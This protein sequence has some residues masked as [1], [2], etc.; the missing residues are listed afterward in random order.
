MFW[1]IDQPSWT[2]WLQAVTKS[3]SLDLELNSMSTTVSKKCL[4]QL[5]HEDKKPTL[6]IKIYI[7]QLFTNYF[8]LL[9][10]IRSFIVGGKHT[11]QILWLETPTC[12]SALLW[13]LTDIQR[14]PGWIS[15]NF[16]FWNLNG[17][18][19]LLNITN[20]SKIQNRTD[21]TLKYKDGI[22]IYN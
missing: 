3:S 20:K 6:N 1:V 21:S 18:K 15:Q 11:T 2:V 9:N 7:F 4:L 19:W 22:K 17:T 8:I 12:S 16:T 14:Q 5:N 13:T 10:L